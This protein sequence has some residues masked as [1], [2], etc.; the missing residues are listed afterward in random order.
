MVEIE[1]NAMV[2]VQQLGHMMPESKQYLKAENFLL[3]KESIFWGAE[4]LV[5]GNVRTHQIEI[6]VA[7]RVIF[8]CG[9]GSCQETII[10]LNGMRGT[11]KAVTNTSVINTSVIN[12]SVINTSS[13]PH[14]TNQSQVIF[15]LSWFTRRQV[16]FT[17]QMQPWWPAALVKAQAWAAAGQIQKGD[18]IFQNPKLY[19]FNKNTCSLC[20]QKLMCA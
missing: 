17:G 15:S 20:P 6:T 13:T 2:V 1:Q 7:D 10:N 11:L 16:I 19:S 18:T 12:T 5:S 3:Y 14:S 9:R 8:Y 4:L